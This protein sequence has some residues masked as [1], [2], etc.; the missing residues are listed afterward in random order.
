MKKI[1]LKQLIFPILL[2]ILSLAMIAATPKSNF[3]SPR[4]LNYKS[5]FEDFYNQELPHVTL[6]VPGLKYSGF[7][8]MVDKQ[9]RG[10]YYYTLINDCCQFYVLSEKTKSMIGDAS[11]SIDLRGRLIKLDTIEYETLIKDMATRLNWSAASLKHVTSPY[12]IST[13]SYP[14][15]FDFLFFGVLYGCVLISCIDILII[16][17]KIGKHKNGS[18]F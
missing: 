8:Y 7:D 18:G 5:S 15:Y 10:Y 13:I 2:L 14:L 9:V 12:A 17:W 6:S 16:L 11:E 3:L 1:L 4:P